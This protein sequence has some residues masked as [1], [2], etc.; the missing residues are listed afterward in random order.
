MYDLQPNDVDD[1]NNLVVAIVLQQFWDRLNDTVREFVGAK[2]PK[3][4]HQAAIFAYMSSATNR[5]KRDV[6]FQL[7]F[8]KP[9][10]FA[11]TSSQHGGGAANDNCC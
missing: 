5:T 6:K 3:T 7:R 11:K 2:E 9:T 8:D 10:H 4:P 1:F